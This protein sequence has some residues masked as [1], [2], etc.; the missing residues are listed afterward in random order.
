[1]PA[2][3]AK[4]RGF[5]PLHGSEVL[6][7]TFHGASGEVTGSSFLLETRGGKAL[8]DCGMYQ[9]G[10]D[11]G[12]KNRRPFPYDARGLTAVLLT[13]AHID[14][15]G[16]LPKLVS[17]GFAG[18]IYATQATCDL[19]AIMLPDAAHIHE[20]E[21]TQ[22]TRR[23]E[24]HHGQGTRRFE[25]LYTLADAER[26]LKQLVPV[27]V[28]EPFL[29]LSDAEV[30]LYR[31]GH[32][33]GATSARLRLGREGAQ[34]TI[35]F[36]GDVGRVSEPL[37]LNPQAPEQADLCILE[38]TYGD[39]DHK[40]HAASMAEFARIL[41]AA[42]EDGGNVII[43]VFAVGRAQEV[44]YDLAWLEREGR[45]T[46][47]PVHLDSPMAIRV[48]E[49][50]GRHRQSFRP[51]V[52]A[53][54]AR[55]TSEGP[56]AAGTGLDPR[57]L[58]FCRT[59]E[60]SRALNGREGIVILAASGMCEAG[61]V[62]HHLRHNLWRPRAQ[63]LIVGFQAGGTLGRA[64]VEGAREV[65]IFGERIAVRAQIHTV[66]GFSAHAGQSE[67]L[68]WVRPM[69][70][71]GAEV[72]LV[73]AEEEKRQALAGRLAAL[74]SRD[75]HLPLPGTSVVFSAGAARATWAQATG[76]AHSRS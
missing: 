56:G 1:V 16:L 52:R 66:G 44:L 64:L 10:R 71:S 42:A 53:E 29:L 49:L 4:R 41:D 22:A 31:A 25:P 7:L 26:T 74:T 47:R 2:A 17:A 58:S 6:R 55:S 38:A 69:L 18:P 45:L 65:K 60:E 61:R 8:V 35:V 46:P 3:S 40:D 19:L 27:A 14:H 5:R 51:E 37:L 15:S 63:V 34:R 62:V 75:V 50:Y 23:Y 32:I 30:E 9:G 13:H 39:R 28:G 24:R 43:P 33:L 36:S 70:T 73:H 59:P 11:A 21:A 57:E 68:S 76:S 20:Q 67:L 54:L 48:T 72:A 12:Q